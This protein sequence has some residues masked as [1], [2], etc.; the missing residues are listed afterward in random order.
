MS[1]CQKII[2]GNAQPNGGNGIVSIAG[3]RALG[4]NDNLLTQIANTNIVSPF[5]P[6]VGSQLDQSVSVINNKLDTRFDDIE[7]YTLGSGNF[8]GA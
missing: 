6:Y 7:Y 2:S 1:V 5:P 3:A 4:M 8:I